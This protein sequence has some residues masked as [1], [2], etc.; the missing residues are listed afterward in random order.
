MEGLV[1]IDRS[2]LALILVLTSGVLASQGWLLAQTS[3]TA[4]AQLKAA[5]HTEEVE[6]DLKSA[7][8]QYRKLAQNSDRAVAATAL[9]RMAASY[10]RLGQSDARAAYERVVREFADQ[11]ASVATA[12]ARLASLR[13]APAAANVLSLRRVGDGSQNEHGAAVSYD[14]RYIAH[15]LH[16]DSL[17]TLAV[18]ELATGKVYPLAVRAPDSRDQPDLAVMSRDSKMVAYAWGTTN[19]HY[20]LRTIPLRTSPG[21]PRRLFRTE[22][23]AATFPYDWSPD[24]TQIAVVLFQRDRPA[25]IG[26]V[27]ASD[28]SLKVLRSVDSRFATNNRMSFSPDGKYLAY[29]LAQVDHPEQRDVF[30]MTVDGSRETAA[31]AHP[32]HNTMAGWSPDGTHLLFFSDRT[33]S[34]GLWSQA[35]ADGR[36]QGAATLIKADLGSARS[37][38]MTASGALY[39]SSPVDDI[40]IEVVPVDFASGR[41]VGSPVRPITSYMGANSQPEWS[42]DGRFM[43]YVSRR[44]GR[45]VL[46]MRELA[47]ENVRV[48]RPQLSTVA[49]KAWSPDRKMFVVQ[50]ADPKGLAGLFAVDAETG[51]AS[52]LVAG[53]GPAPAWSPDGRKLYYA[54]SMD[55]QSVVL[56]R[57]MVS[58]EAREIFRH[59]ILSGGVNLSPD[60][61]WI[62]YTSV[63]PAGTFAAAI[64]FPA[65]G[66]EPREL[67]RVNRPLH[68]GV[69]FWAPDSS[70]VIVGRGIPGDPKFIE[71][72]RIPIS[73]GEPARTD[74][75]LTLGGPP[76]LHPDGRQLAYTTTTESKT[77]IW[78]LE[79]FL[80]KIAEL[81]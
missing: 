18:R 2:R 59:P 9:V 27:S 81:P 30:V 76:R 8:E 56:E 3:R 48:I 34:R 66:G 20:E 36:P 67:M 16:P 23:V 47:T 64:V 68:I 80:P 70:S 43:A 79:N 1:M 52:L 13:M 6:G 21:Q 54:R 40:D 24:G 17:G 4:E 5:Q 32:S 65:S 49:S 29:D 35:V 28:G 25:R 55:K 77:E 53:S 58:G 31:I 73:G 57:D 74:P 51:A 75:R 10:E 61:R 11:A 33:G 14:G 50:G 38:G 37:L 12:R 44:E 39:V 45:L 60:G 7:I 22:D 26:L 41:I 19:G 46:A 15:H 62:A 42:S 63:D 78:V 72:W 69:A 71:R